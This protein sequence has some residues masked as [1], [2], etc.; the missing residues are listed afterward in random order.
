[1]QREWQWLEIIGEK[2]PLAMSELSYRSASVAARTAADSCGRSLPRARTR[3]SV[4]RGHAHA[5]RARALLARRAIVCLFFLVQV[6][7]ND[8]SASTYLHCPGSFLRLACAR[9]RLSGSLQM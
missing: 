6:N 8:V 3:M 4:S 2:K 1:M 7:E 5:G 9:C